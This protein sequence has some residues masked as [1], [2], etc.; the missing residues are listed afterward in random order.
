MT[1]RPL[2]GIVNYQAGNIRS[3][4]NAFE[5][6]GA[7]VCLVAQAEELRNCSHAVLPGVGAFGFCADRL[8]ATG[9]ISEIEDWAFNQQRPLLGICVGMQLMADGSEETPRVA[10]LGWFGGFVRRLPETVD[11]SVRVPH[12]GWNTVT[13]K[14]RCG[15]FSPGDQADFYFDHSYAWDTPV[16]G[17]CMASCVHGRT[18]SGVV[19]HGRVWAT[20]FHPEKSQSAGLQLLEGFLSL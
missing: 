16:R 4:T 8:R 10:G 20:Q 6:L 15:S 1:R 19:G 11:A 12:V 17:E 13:F 2:V 5:H 7:S 14:A 3:I 9:L 18:F